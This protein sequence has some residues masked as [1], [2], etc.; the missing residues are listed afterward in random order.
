LVAASWAA[1]AKA[2]LMIFRQEYA[3]V[4]KL[5]KAGRQAAAARGDGH[6]EAQRWLA[7][8]NARLEQVRAT[9]P[10]TP[11]APESEQAP[12]P[13]KRLMEA[14]M[15]AQEALHLFRRFGDSAGEA[16]ALL[17]LAKAQR[18]RRQPRLALEAA[19][20]AV[21][22]HKVVGEFHGAAQALLLEATTQLLIAGTA[23][24]DDQ[25]EVQARPALEGPPGAHKQALAAAAEALALCR[26]H[27]RDPELED[28]AK[29]VAEAAREPLHVPPPLPAEAQQQQRPPVVVA[30]APQERGP[31]EELGYKFASA[32]QA[33]GLLRREQDVRLEALLQ[34]SLEPLLPMAARPKTQRPDLAMERLADMVRSSQ[35]R[36]K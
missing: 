16:S 26:G 8:A 7:Q 23:W 32:T 5:A 20:Q 12:L 31:M 10:Y 28:Y 14:F 15:A 11:L 1:A 36:A 35:A 18:F 27:F 25:D 21:T 6:G 24:E 9:C 33:R 30:F 22:V 29:Q 17:T 3:E 4:L 19:R 13:G 2:N 34:R